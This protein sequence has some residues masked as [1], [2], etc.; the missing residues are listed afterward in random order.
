VRKLNNKKEK[1]T[2]I[3]GV[4]ITAIGKTTT[5]FLFLFYYYFRVI[6][7]NVV[8]SVACLTVDGHHHLFEYGKL[9]GPD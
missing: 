8:F 2:K 7:Y 1:E 5:E 9:N 4:D 3:D 6:S